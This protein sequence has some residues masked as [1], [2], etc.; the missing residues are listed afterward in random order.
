[1]VKR[2]GPGERIRRLR[3]LAGLSP[4]GLGKLSILAGTGIW[5]IEHG[6]NKNPTLETLQDIAD[7]FGVRVSYLTNGEGD[8]PSPEQLA[9]AVAASRRSEP[10]R[11]AAKLAARRAAKVAR[12]SAPAAASTAS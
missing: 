11:R 6:K 8:E 3:E 10:R 7:V 4:R 9:S 12:G 5:N 2:I 1:M